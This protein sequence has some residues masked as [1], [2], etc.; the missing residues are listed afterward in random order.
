MTDAITVLYVRYC[1]VAADVSVDVD[2]AQTSKHSVV[3]RVL[4]AAPRRAFDSTR[5]QFGS[6]ES[7]TGCT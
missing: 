6:V 5:I 2:V 3:Y 4:H 1:T 7:F